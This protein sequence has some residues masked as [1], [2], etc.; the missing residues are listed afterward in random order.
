M[1]GAE[2]ALRHH[3]SV[4]VEER[5][6]EVAPLE[7]TNWKLE[8]TCVLPRAAFAG[9]GGVASGSGAEKAAR[10]AYIPEAGGV[11][12]C[13]VWDRYRLGMDARLEGPAIV[14]ER[15]TTVLLLPG[16]TGRIDEHGNLLIE[17]GQS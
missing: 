15:E 8:L 4:G 14:E 2:V 16:D 1:A 9:A 10:R 12:E 11:V 5:H 6:G 17:I 13:P 3:L 7:V